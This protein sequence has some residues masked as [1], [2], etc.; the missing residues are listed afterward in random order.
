MVAHH[1]DIGLDLA[2]TTYQQH[3]LDTG[4]IRRARWVSSRTGLGI[5]YISSSRLS[6]RSRAQHQAILVHIR[7]R[8]SIDVLKAHAGTGPEIG[9]FVIWLPCVMAK[10]SPRPPQA[11]LVSSNSLA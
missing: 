3:I 8:F 4:G 1:Q 5:A 11:L 2:L 9:S 6:A 10:L 7:V